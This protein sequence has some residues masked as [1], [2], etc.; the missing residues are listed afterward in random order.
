M[1]EEGEPCDVIYTDF[2]KAFDSVTHQRLCKLEYLGI[3][4][5]VLNWVRSFLSGRTQRVKV[6]GFFSKWAKVSSV[7]PHG[8]VLGPLLFVVLK[9]I[10]QTGSNTVFAKCSRMIVR[11]IDV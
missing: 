9:M 7:I 2:S 11:S 5:D 10:Y 3:R 6:D 8:S 4:G 1:I